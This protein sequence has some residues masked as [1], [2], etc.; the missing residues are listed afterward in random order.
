MALRQAVLVLAM[1]ACVSGFMFYQSRI[2]NGDRVTDPCDNSVW[3]GVGHE[4]RAGGGV[5]NP[6]GKVRS[7][8]AYR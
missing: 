5:K 2:P 3:E 8:G 1:T 4:N 6:F 7:V